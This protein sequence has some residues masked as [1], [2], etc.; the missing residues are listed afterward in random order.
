M[1][2]EQKSR[3]Q[4]TRELKVKAVELL[5]HGDGASQIKVGPCNISKIPVVGRSII[6]CSSI[7]SKVV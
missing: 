3:R 2:E 5:L 4:Y 7:F 1:M 6:S